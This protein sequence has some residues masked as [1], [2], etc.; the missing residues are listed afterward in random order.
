MAA[1]FVLSV[2]STFA[3]ASSAGRATA[4]DRS[5]A[6]TT[7]TNKHHPVPHFTGTLATIWFISGLGMLFGALMLGYLAIRLTRRA[8]VPIGDLHLPPLLWLSTALVLVA[9]VTVQLAVR[10]IR[11]ERQDLLRGWLV[12]TLVVGLLFVFVQAPSL[13]TLVQEH[14]ATMRQFDQAGGGGFTDGMPSGTIRPQPFFGIIFVFILVHA[15]HVAGGIVQLVLVIRNAFAGRFDHEYYN[16]VK[17]T[18]M[19]WHFLD[20]V[21][22][23]MF[24]TMV[25]LG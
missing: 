22:L 19:Y 10:A 8:D 11:R 18:A 6:V 1:F 16:P 9:S 5:H 20:V 23:L 14:L 15:A 12:A 3:T 24:G 13:T 17:H 7:A 2:F 21:W 25:T 4:Y